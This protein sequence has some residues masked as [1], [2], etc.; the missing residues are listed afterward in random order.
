MKIQKWNKKDIIFP[1]HLDEIY[2]NIDFCDV[3][4]MVDKGFVVL[5]HQPKYSFYKRLGIPEIQD[6][7]VLPDYRGQGIATAL[8]QFC[9]KQIHGDMVGISVPISPQFGQ[10]QRLY[11]KLGYKPDGNG[12]TYE[13]E[14]VIHNTMARVDDNL[15]LMMVKDLK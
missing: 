3:F 14:Q 4:Y 6:V 9:E 13:R 15:C 11:Y 12:V 5:N 1:Q 2:K 7:F 8:I 10:A